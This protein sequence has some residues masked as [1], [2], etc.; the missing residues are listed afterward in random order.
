VS[1]ATLRALSHGVLWAGIG[2]HAALLGY[3]LVAGPV[4]DAALPLL[5]L[6]LLT[7]WL[8]VLPRIE[9]QI[10]TRHALMVE[11]LVIAQAVAASLEPPDG[12]ATN[13]RVSG[14]G[15]PRVQ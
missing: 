7:T 5:G 8:S 10:D 1:V 2:F 4:G 6:A 15:A 9:A 11:Q 12:I 3:R 14:P 13:V